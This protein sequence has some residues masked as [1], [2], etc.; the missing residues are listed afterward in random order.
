MMSTISLIVTIITINISFRK[1][2]V[3]IPRFIRITALRGLAKLLLGRKVAPCED[4]LNAT[5][6]GAERMQQNLT[7]K[8]LD[9]PNAHQKIKPK[10]SEM[11][12]DMSAILRE[13][14]IITRHLREKEKED[15]ISSEWKLLSKVID[16]LLFWSLL[17]ILI[18]A[19]IAIQA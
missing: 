2:P 8:E 19:I 9:I 15:E 14:K 5:N 1:S 18:I 4:E 3:R 10:E 17:I 16:R 11:N 12:E 6:N 13:L 7:T